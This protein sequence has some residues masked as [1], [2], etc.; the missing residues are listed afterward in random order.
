MVKPDR[1]VMSLFAPDDAALRLARAPDAVV[2]PVPPYR[3]AMGVP[4][5]VPLEMVAREADPDA[6]RLVKAP[7]LGVDEPIGVPSMLPPVMATV[8]AFCVAIVPRPVTDVL[9]MVIGTFEAALNC[10]LAR[11]VNCGT[12]E[13][14]P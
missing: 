9:G 1:L 2:A 5:H 10:P 3:T 11:T 13:A 12:V 4:F 14:E 8:L 7:V 6:L